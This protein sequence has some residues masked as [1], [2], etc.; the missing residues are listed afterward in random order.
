VFRQA[1][2]LASAC[3]LGLFLGAVVAQPLLE[4]AYDPL[5]QEIS[6]F[7]HTGVGAVA[8]TAFGAW[9]VSLV[10]LASLVGASAES[11]A[12]SRAARFEAA[13][14]LAAA[15]GLGLVALF[16]TDRGAEIAGAVTETTSAGR[17]HDIGSGLTSIAIFVAIVADAGRERDRLLAAAV[18]SAA[19]LSS[20]IL[21]T[22]GDPLPGL[23]Q[24]CLVACA[25]LWQAVVLYRLW[26]RASTWSE[27]NADSRCSTS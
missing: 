11:G 17:V 9:A 14:L 3:G 18:I 13:A 19:L 15:V 26:T 22:S 4:P 2:I 25:G 20:S 12:F 24:R 5:R 8:A 7:V 16:A 6:E 27:S 10:A 1:R 23:R 21:F